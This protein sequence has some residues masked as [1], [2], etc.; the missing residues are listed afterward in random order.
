MENLSLTSILIGI[1][2]SILANL[3]TPYISRFFRWGY[4]SMRK[5]KVKELRTDISNAEYFSANPVYLH[6]YLWQEAYL[7]AS[8]LILAFILKNFTV[9][10]E[11]SKFIVEKVPG[12]LFA[13]SFGTALK[14]YFLIKNVRNPSNYLKNK[15][16]QLERIL[17]ELE[18]APP[19]DSIPSNKQLEEKKD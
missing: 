18:P 3:W 5:S 11:I 8:L 16:Q 1:A 10:G 7:I 4:D 15:K 2:L 14:N 13:F 9:T 17:S 12:G 19:S 6:H